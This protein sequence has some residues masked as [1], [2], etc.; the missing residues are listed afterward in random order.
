LLNTIED[1][2]GLIIMETALLPKTRLKLPGIL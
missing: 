2:K 1:K